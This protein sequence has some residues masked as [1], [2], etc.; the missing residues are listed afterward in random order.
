MSVHRLGLTCLFK[1]LQVLLPVPA[2][3]PHQ[4]FAVRGRTP[5]LLQSLLQG[6]GGLQHRSWICEHR[7]KQISAAGA[8]TARVTRTNASLSKRKKVCFTVCAA[9]KPLYSFLRRN[10][11]TGGLFR[12]D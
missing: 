8:T 4:R 12:R 7:Q 9:C 6:M 11:N 5:K 3:L 10:F 2:D 1:A